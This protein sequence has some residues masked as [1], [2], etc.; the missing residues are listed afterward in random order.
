M[1]A[2]KQAIVVV[3]ASLML[4]AGLAGCLGG[5]GTA[6]IFVKDTHIDDFESIE[7]TFSAVHV[8]EGDS[9]DGGGSGDQGDQGGQGMQGASFQT[10]QESGARPDTEASGWTTV[11][12][13]TKTIDLLDFNASDARAFLGQANL[14]AGTYN[15][16]VVDVDSAVGTKNDGSTVSFTVTTGWFR[17]V[18]AWQVEADQDTRIVIDLDLE[19]S[20]VKQGTDDWRF[21]P[22]IGQVLVEDGDGSTSSVSGSA[23]GGGDGDTGSQTTYVKDTPEQNFTEVWIRFTK[24]EVRHASNDTLITTVD[25]PR[26]LDLLRFNESGSKAFLG[27]KQMPTGRYTQIKI[28]IDSAWG[29]DNNGTNQSIQLTRSTAMTAG[30]WNVSEGETTQVTIDVNLSRS[31]HKQGGD[32]QDGGQAGD[33]GDGWRLTPV[34]GRIIVAEGVDDDPRA[35]QAD[36]GEDQTQD[37][38]GS[39]TTYVKDRPEHNFTEVWVA[40][41]SVEVHYAGND[42]WITTVDEDRT[43]DLMAYNESGSKAFLGES[44]LP[45][46][47]YTQ[48]RVNVT[49]AWGINNTGGNETFDLVD[50]EYKIVRTWNVSAN[51]TTQVVIDINLTRALHQQGDGGQ[52][53]GDG[54]GWRFTPV[55]GQILVT[56]GI[57]DDPRADVP[58][59][60]Q[61]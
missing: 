15:Q 31:L 29:I 49:D 54:D 7:I 28:H 25:E 36:Q 14:S 4:T 17:I 10:F 26:N 40:F 53:G 1:R 35:D 23:G 41:D 57:D 32:G 9:E 52:Y 20:I 38:T 44:E 16:I 24:V 34:I 48:I 3:T 42:S 39:Q 59:E 30:T 19:Q 21:N 43:L 27:D 37:Q 58:D 12:E 2:G 46:G 51:Q 56:E 22:V 61:S 33:G 50:T 47:R 6:T 45:A 11:S 8:H 55:I 13:E 18:R 60:G 5:T